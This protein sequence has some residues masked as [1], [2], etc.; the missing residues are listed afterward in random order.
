M[1]KSTAESVTSAPTAVVEN[2]SH[3]PTGSVTISGT[4]REDEV[5]TASH[6]LSRRRWPRCN[7]LAVES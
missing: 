1:E 7:E 2:K 6:T 5:L 4:A 3:A